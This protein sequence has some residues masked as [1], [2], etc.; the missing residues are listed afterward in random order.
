MNILILSPYPPYPPRSGG[1]LRIY[2]LLLGL[3]QRHRVTCLTFAPDLA[4]IT[5]LEP[6]R[7]HC[8]LVTVWESARR[9]L[10]RR[11]TTTLTSPLPDM[12][13][14]SASRTYS[15][16]LGYL[17]R[18]QRFDVV[19]A[20][21]I[22]MAQ[23]GL[24]AQHSGARAL[25]DQFNAEYVLQ[26]R[27]ALTDLRQSGRN[28]RSLVAGPYS[29]VQWAKLARYERHMLRRYDAVVAVSEEDRRALLRLE[30]SARIGIVPNGVDT[31]YFQ[32]QPAQAVPAA[33]DM[34]F[35]GTLDFRPN[36]DAVVW[37]AREVLP[38]VRARHPAARF[39]VV[40]R[41]PS[42]AV[43]ALHDGAAVVVAPDVADIRSYIAAAAVYVVPMRMGGGIRLK[44]LEALAMQAAVV[45]TTM[46]A[47]GVPELHADEH[48]VL[49]DTA[50]TFADAVIS[51]LDDPARRAR[52][53]SAGRMLVARH[54][55]W[56]ALLPRLENLYG[57]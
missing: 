2:N 4:A 17:L 39:V 42:P 23:Y 48:L 8:G 27:A 45:C 54:Y 20:E 12:A 7:A 55:D 52:L 1:A 56:K 53:G 57:F 5:A 34:V 26:R 24:L 37:F 40:G 35:T 30:D 36:V 44:L 25:L 31:A 29:L 32:P 33:Q 28:P 10:L 49:A 3:A 38:L 16:A 22:E 6:L 21:S 51:L 50:Q 18:A 19:Q 41:S 9:S 43:R 15:A 14:R 46:G 13:L 47:E 11:A